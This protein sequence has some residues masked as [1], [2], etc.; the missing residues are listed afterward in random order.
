MR[1]KVNRKLI[2]LLPALILA[3]LVAM[4]PGVTGATS[5][6]GGG[7]SS[8]DFTLTGC[9]VSASG[10]TFQVDSGGSI[11]TVSVEYTST[12]AVPALNDKVTVSGERRGGTNEV[13]VYKLSHRV[14]KID[15]CTVAKSVAG[16]TTAPSVAQMEETETRMQKGCCGACGGSITTKLIDKNK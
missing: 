6:P 5:P 1:V 16:S 3:C 11:Y 15:T 12:A 14:I 7:S 2:L 9:V 4:L 13:R 10:S 8:G